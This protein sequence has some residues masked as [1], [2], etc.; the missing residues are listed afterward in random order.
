MNYKNEIKSLLKS[1]LYAIKGIM[2]CINNERNMRIHICICVLLSIFS[3]C[4]KVTSSEFI[5]IIICMGFVVSS[6]ML[7]TAIETLV[8]LAS[9]SYHS[10]AKAAKDIAAGSVM[11]SSIVALIVGV[12]IFFDIDRLKS[13]INII[14]LSPFL[15]FMF[16]ISIVLSMLFIFN[17][18]P[19]NKE[20]KTKIYLIN[21]SNKKE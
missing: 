20:K 19:I 16:I 1:F 15:I 9:P 13:A 21:E 6:E 11:I 4:Y 3:Y 8:N 5:A 7:N 10:L 18:Y 14:L 12:F 17:N 2:Y